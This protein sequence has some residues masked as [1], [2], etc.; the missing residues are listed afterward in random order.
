M[1]IE[2]NLENSLKNSAVIVSYIPVS[3]RRSGV[4]TSRIKVIVGLIRESQS[5]VSLRWTTQLWNCGRREVA[6]VDAWRTTPGSQ[7]DEEVASCEI[8]QVGIRACACKRLG[9]YILHI[10]CKFYSIFSELY[11]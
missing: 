11:L 1:C 4:V 2:H 3:W 5:A 6:V 9:N 7:R 10:L 8:V